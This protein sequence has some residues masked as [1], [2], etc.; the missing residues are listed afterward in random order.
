MARHES[1]FTK[2][3][4]ESSSIEIA[5]F[6]IEPVRQGR[7]AHRVSWHSWQPWV[8]LCR[9]AVVDWRCQEEV[10]TGTCKLILLV[11]Y[12]NIDPQFGNPA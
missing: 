7:L 10:S 1:S 3:G 8:R 9:K 12:G 4:E 6:S 5:R 2:I 11:L